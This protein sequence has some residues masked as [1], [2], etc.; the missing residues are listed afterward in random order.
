MISTGTIIVK[1]AEGQADT[2][3][4]VIVSNQIDYI[5]KVSVIIPIHNAERYLRAS[6]DSVMQQTLRE[7]EIICVDDGSTDGSVAILTEYAAQDRRITLICQQ[8]INAGVA[9]NAGLSV[10]RGEYLSFLDADDF[11]ELNMYELLYERARQMQAQIC[12]YESA[13]YNM[14]KGTSYP[15][16]W[17]LKREQLPSSICFSGEDI[18]KYIFNFALSWTW[19]KFFEAR[20]I[21]ENNIRFQ[22]IRRTNDLYFVYLALSLARRITTL[23]KPLIHYRTGHGN[24]LQATNANSPKDWYY[25]LMLLKDKLAKLGLFSRYEQ[26]FV[27]AALGGCLYNL[28]SIQ[29]KKIKNQLR[30]ELVSKLAYDVGIMKH[31]KYKSYFYNTGSY[32]SFLK[33]LLDT[34]QNRFFSLIYHSRRTENYMKH[35]VLGI[36]V[37]KKR[38][39]HV[40]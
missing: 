34:P 26:S 37:F 25:A 2:S 31:I 8:N 33:L 1:N 18:Q 38:I 24:N 9:R 30:K 17:G 3:A 19:N 12:V 16:P 7:I 28:H 36:Q 5:P 10:A 20:F 4:D 27:N 32:H 21:R 14:R 13:C 6:L 35:Y 40:S 11:F 22:S 29:D 39:E 15:M 23:N